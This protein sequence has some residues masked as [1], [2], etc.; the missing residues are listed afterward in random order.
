MLLQRATRWQRDGGEARR[1]RVRRR[2][3]PGPLRLPETACF[4]STGLPPPRPRGAVTAK[5]PAQL[6]R[7]E[8]APYTPALQVHFRKKRSWR[9]F[10][11][12]SD[13]GRTTDSREQAVEPLSCIGILGRPVP[14]NALAIC[15][16]QL[17]QFQRISRS[18]QS[19]NALP[20]GVGLV[21]DGF[22][23]PARRE[24]A[25]DR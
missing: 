1:R 3:C 13:E 12:R 4:G 9:Q 24:K 10:S 20:L 22:R 11:D 6:P 17:G 19:R 21:E 15:V 7:P 8:T 16:A 2:V 18:G 5:S 14:G 23:L 25:I